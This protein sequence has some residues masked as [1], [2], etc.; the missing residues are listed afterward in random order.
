MT[1]LYPH[2]GL[3]PGEGLFPGEGPEIAAPSGAVIDNFNRADENP[4]SKNKKWFTVGAHGLQVVGK[5]ARNSVTEG[6]VFAI[7]LFGRQILNGGLGKTVTNATTHLHRIYILGDASTSNAYFADFSAGKAKLRKRI[8]GVESTIE[9]VSLALSLGSGIFAQRE[10]GNLLSLWHKPPAGEWELV[11]YGIDEDIES[12]YRGLSTNSPN[13]RYDDVFGWEEVAP[14]PPPLPK[15]TNGIKFARYAI[16]SPP[17]GWIDPVSQPDEIF[18]TQWWHTA[19]IAAA[20]ALGSKILIYLNLTRAREPSG[21]GHQNSGLTLKEAE[22]V[23]AV[24]GE[25][26]DD[27][28]GWVCK[29]GTPGDAALWAERA[30]ARAKEVGADGVF[31]DDM[32]HRDNTGGE[33]TDDQWREQMQHCNEVV[34]A[35]LQ[36]EGLLAIANLAGATGQ[37]N[38]ETDGWVED[39]LQFFS[40]GFEEFFVTFPN[41][42]VQSTAR[43]EESCSIMHNSQLAGSDKYYI[44]TV[45]SNKDEVIRFALACAL[46]ETAGKVLF[47]ATPGPPEGGTP[48]SPDYRYEKWTEAHE[49][50]LKLGK[51]TQEALLREDGVWFRQFQYGYITVDLR[52]KSAT[53]KVEKRYIAVSREFPPDNL[54]VRISDP[55][56]GRTIVRLS[57]DEADLSNVI[58]S[59]GYDSEMQGGSKTLKG[60]LGRDPR[61]PWSDLPAYADV[62]VYSDGVEELWWGRV[63]KLQ[64]AEGVRTGVDLEAVGHIAALEDDKA[65]LGL[66]F[67]DADQSKWGEQSV[68]RRKQLIEAGIKLE[69]NTSFGFGS[70][71]DE[72]EP[73]SILNDFNGVT[74]A[75]GKTEAGEADYD[76]GGVDIDQVLYDYRVLAVPDASFESTV[77]LGTTDTF[78]TAAIGTDH[79]GTTA[80]QQQVSAP[81]AGYRFA[82][83]RDLYG[84][85]FEGSMTNLFAWQYL[86]V[87]ARTGLALQGTWPNVGYT[88]KQMLGYAVPRYSYLEARDEDLEDDGF[89]IPHAWF[90][91]PGDLRAVLAGDTRGVRAQ[92]NRPRRKPT[93]AGNRRRLPRRRRQHQ[94]RRPPRLGRAPRRPPPG[95]NRSGSPCG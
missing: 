41:E 75:P 50:A 76:S 47:F 64:G 19:E 21:E 38:L 1:D 78:A 9:E 52:T 63:E 24:S 69:A 53:I 32:N 91:E 60:N 62:T 88:A 89:V 39:Q 6:F 73:P 13:T 42:E 37:R 22:S 67:I 92:R 94:I 29:P 58:N 27:A 95:N 28:G 79:N 80:L 66:G 17:S 85:T 25:F 55:Q 23:G 72:A 3:Y 87:L 43:I 7:S 86:K 26:D 57:E 15:A 2:P 12:G 40:G 45:N 49:Q 74:A 16:A 46:L 20:R 83:L 34:G 82:R 59:I 4:L 44:V 77:A 71:E 14:P 68:E 90:S 30:I 18:V 35:A 56:T 10:D 93:V 8:G 48:Q 84:G 5:E 33:L 54:A 81:G 70:M 31:L 65:C 36:A 11:V 51:P 61:V